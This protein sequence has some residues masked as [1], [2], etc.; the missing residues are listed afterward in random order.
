MTRSELYTL[1]QRCSANCTILPSL[2]GNV[3]ILMYDTDLIHIF[4]ARN[5]KM[6]AYE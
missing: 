2:H 3:A 4:A 6:K 1:R 5:K